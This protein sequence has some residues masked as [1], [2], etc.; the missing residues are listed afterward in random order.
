M[1]LENSSP[2]PQVPVICPYPKPTP[3]SPHDPP[4]TFWRPILILSS[5]LRLGLPNGL[6]PSDFPTN[7][8]C[9]T[10]SSPIRATCPA[11]LILLDFTTTGILT[12]CLLGLYFMERSYR[13]QYDSFRFWE[14]LTF[15]L[16]LAFCAKNLG[17]YSL[18][19][20]QD[21]CLLPWNK[22]RPSTS[23]GLLKIISQNKW[24]LHKQC[25]GQ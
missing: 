24:T 22:W 19:P 5:H 17:D 11:H 1:E 3:S 4:P 8:L 20:F 13:A 6:F 18:R 25:C 9:T 21:S 2:Y 14:M 15:I 12:L 23:S 16:L 7:T 10:L